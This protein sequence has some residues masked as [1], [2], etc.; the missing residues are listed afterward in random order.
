MGPKGQFS[1][2]TEGRDTATVHAMARMGAIEHENSHVLD[3][4]VGPEVIAVS[5]QSARR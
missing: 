3:T 1:S 2:G 4:S 5:S